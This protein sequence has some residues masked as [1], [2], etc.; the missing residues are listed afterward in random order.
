MTTKREAFSLTTAGEGFAVRMSSMLP[1][2]TGM[3][4][5]NHN[6]AW[7]FTENLKNYEVSFG[8]ISVFVWLP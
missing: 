4:L 1:I 7:H 2:L 5:E 8:F 6:L 3:S